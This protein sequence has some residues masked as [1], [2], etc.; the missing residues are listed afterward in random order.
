MTEWTPIDEA[1]FV[2]GQISPDDVA[3]AADRGFALIINNRPDAEEDDQPDGALIAAAAKAAGIAYVSIPVG[4]E[5]IGPEQI[6]AMACALAEA[7]GDILAFCRSGNR[8][9]MLWALSQAKQG[10]D[11]DIVAEM[12][13]DAGYNPVLILPVMKQLAAKAA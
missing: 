10:R 12:V 7:D 11:P 8:S 3:R 4:A 5:G 6:D 1:V 2:A 13:R 9:S